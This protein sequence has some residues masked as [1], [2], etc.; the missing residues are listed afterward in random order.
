VIFRKVGDIHGEGNA[1]GNLGA[2]YLNLGQPVKAIEFLK[3]SEVIFQNRLQIIFPWKDDLQK[4]NGD[5]QS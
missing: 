4:L 5:T 3:A 1:L 2:A